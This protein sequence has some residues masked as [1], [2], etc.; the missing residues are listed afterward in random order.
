MI[1]DGDAAKRQQLESKSRQIRLAEQTIT[2]LRTEI[3]ALNQ[4]LADLERLR[5]C[6][7]DAH[8]QFGCALQVVSAKV[9]ALEAFRETSKSAVGFRESV[10]GVLDGSSR[11]HCTNKIDHGIEILNQKINKLVL[12][13]ELKSSGLASAN[14]HM[15]GLKYEY[16]RLQRSL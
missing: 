4:D 16:S 8:D 3:S 9:N 6:C 7:M 12:K 14:Q 11:T 2:T 10:M 13:I 5:D 1:M 15:S